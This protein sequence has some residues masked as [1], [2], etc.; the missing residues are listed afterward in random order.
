[1][2]GSDNPFPLSEIMTQGYE[3]TRKAMESY[4]DFV[5]KN[6]KAAP[7]LDTDLTKKMKTFTEQNIAA[8]SEFAQKA[9]KA[10]DFQDFWRIQTEFMQAQW[11]AFTEQ[12]KELTDSAAKG[13]T[14]VMKGP[15][16]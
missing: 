6:V 7:W 2:A 13:A 16:T 14:N 8:A 4:L 9:S 11:K 5:E 1:M 3:Q 10:K 15:S 12:T